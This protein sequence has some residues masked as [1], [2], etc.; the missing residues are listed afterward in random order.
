MDI[1][2]SYICNRGTQRENNE[3]SILINGEIFM[4]ANGEKIMTNVE[5]AL[6][7]VAD[8]MGGAM[9]GEIAAK[10]VLETLVQNPMNSMENIFSTLIKANEEL[11]LYAEKNCDSLEIGSAVAGLSL[12]GNTAHVFNVGDCR[13]YRKNE[14]FLQQV[15]KD[16]SVVGKLLEQGIISYEEVRTHPQRS[17]LTCALSSKTD[18]NS[19]EIYYREL[20]LSNEE[21]FLLCSDGLWDV[22]DESE[23]ENCINMQN[24]NR[25]VSLF[26]KTIEKGDKDNISIIL[27]E[28]RL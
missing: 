22:L 24:G 27:M 9:Y 28:V 8:G 15:S 18:S 14:D 13:I 20:R 7:I 5:K 6:F 25:A 26:Q 1:K 12:E 23:M 10:I 2:V 4:D 11:H 17:V 16:T 21:T 3:D 19:L